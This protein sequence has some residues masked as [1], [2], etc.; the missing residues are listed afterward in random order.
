[1]LSEHEKRIFGENAEELHRDADHVACRI[2]ATGGEVVMTAY[3]VFPAIDIVYHDAHAKACAAGRGET[4]KLLE[5]AHCLEGRL[6]YQ[7]GE[8]FF[9][10]TPGDLSVSLRTLTPLESRFPTGHYHGVSVLI[11]PE[12]APQCVSCFLQDVNVRPGELIE[13]FCRGG[14]CFVARSSARVKHVFSELYSVPEN[15]RKGYFKVKVL[16]LLLF[17]SALP[18]PEESARKR[19]YTGAQVRLAGE[20]SEYL[21]KNPE[22]RVPLAELAE[23]FSVSVAQIKSAFGGVYGMS[24]AAYIRAQKMHGAADALRTTN[25]T[26]LDIA[27]QYGY[28]NASK[29]AKAFRDVIGVSPNEYR[30]GVERDSCAP[31]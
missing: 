16:E 10:L 6:E 28:D 13:K 8:K 4:R 31:E 19:A 20:I 12:R 18:D 5:I 11:D 26:V 17:L 25:R 1:M 29:F 24:P 3:P 15:I 22:S 23:R 14:S 9:F 7:R 21:L 30:G 2:A 27:G